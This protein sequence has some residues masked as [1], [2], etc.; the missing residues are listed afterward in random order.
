MKQILF[1]TICFF[2]SYFSFAQTTAEEYNYLTKGYKIQI[3]SGLDMKQGYGFK[4]IGFPKTQERSCQFK[5]LINE[6]TH[7]MVATLAIFPAANGDKYYICI[8]TA[9]SSQEV[10]NAYYSS[11]NQI[12]NLSAMKDYAW[13]LTVLYQAQL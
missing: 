2:S 13:F 12:D 7:K 11:L 8:P 3:E 5:G 10:F 6:T 1:L 9:G 4:D